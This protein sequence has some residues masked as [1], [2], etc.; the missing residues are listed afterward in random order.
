[1]RIQI[2]LHQKTISASGILTVKHSLYPARPILVA[3]PMERAL[4]NYYSI[5]QSD[6]MLI[7]DNYESKDNHHRIVEGKY[8]YSLYEK[9]I[10]LNADI[11]ILCSICGLRDKCIEAG[12]KIKLTVYCIEGCFLRKYAGEV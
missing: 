12:H 3:Q 8:L 10:T 6:F 4:N 1:M 5:M 2:V 11:D 7:H 9:Q